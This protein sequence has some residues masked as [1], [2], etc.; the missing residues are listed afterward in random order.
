MSGCG[1]KYHGEGVQ[2]WGR[3]RTRQGGENLIGMMRWNPL[4]ERVMCAPSE[5]VE[6]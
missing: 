6:E 3:A 1:G 2:G 4:A 5:L